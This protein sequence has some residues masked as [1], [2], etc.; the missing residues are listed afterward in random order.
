M[1][2]TNKNK[3]KHRLGTSRREREKNDLNNGLRQD[4]QTV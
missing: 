1:V 2:R 4:E 3:T